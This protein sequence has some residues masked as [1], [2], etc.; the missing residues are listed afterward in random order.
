MRVSIRL[1]LVLEAS[2]TSSQDGV[3]EAP[4][5]TYDFRTRPEGADRRT[6]PTGMEGTP[7]GDP[8]ANGRCHTL[9]C[10][11]CRSA[12]QLRRVDLRNASAVR[13]FL[14]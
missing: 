8:L 10:G 12:A 5:L 1:Q 9:I 7:P 4:I 14:V 2:I 13:C 6:E 3:A 11:I